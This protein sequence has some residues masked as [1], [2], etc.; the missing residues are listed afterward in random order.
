MEKLEKIE[1]WENNQFVSYDV[2]FTFRD[3]KTNKQYILYT[4]MQDENMDIFAAYYNEKDH[5]ID[6]ITDKKEQEIV[7]RVVETIK[8]NI[9]K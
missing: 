6:Y 7:A 9:K 5:T 1:I 8:D 3:K 2:L 4:D